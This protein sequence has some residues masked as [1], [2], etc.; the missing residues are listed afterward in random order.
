MRE[1][2]PDT[3]RRAPTLGF[4][5][6][7]LGFVAVL[8]VAGFVVGLLVQRAVLLE[9]LDDEVRASLEEERQKITRLAA[10]R[11]P[12]TGEPFDG[13]V[14]AIFETFLRRNVP[15]EGEVYLTLVAGDPYISTSSP[16]GVRLDRDQTLVE[17]WAARDAGEAATI[18]SAAGPVDY[19]SIPLTSDGDTEGVFVVANFV[20]GERNEIED[21]IRIAAMVSGLLLVVTIGAAWVI[22]GRL[23]QPVRDLTATAQLISDTDLSRRLRVDGRD[24]MADLAVTFNGMLDRLEVAFNTQRSFIDDASHELRTPIQIVRGHLEL[25]GVSPQERTETVELVTDELDRMARIVNDLLLLSKAEQPDFVQPGEEEL[26]DLTVDLFT[27]VNT[28]GERDW[29]LDGC[30][31]GTLLVDRDRLTQAV[32]NLAR[33]AVEHTQAGDQIALGSSRRG[34][35]VR[36]WVR[37]TG[38]GVAAADRH[39][40]FDRF[41]RGQGNRRRSEGAGLGLSIVDAIVTGHRG[42]IELDSEPGHGATFTVVLPCSA[43]ATSEDTLVAVVRE[44]ADGAAI[45]AAG[46]IETR[47]ETRT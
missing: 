19:L 30:D 24:E 35:E 6:R 1:S 20:R 15:G 18:D 21:H 3:R 10:G 45:P 27:K 37:D 8:L 33:N 43:E 38:P 2:R 14:E 13:D 9:R 11:D 40:I 44:D 7:L 28:L 32:L 23:L 12:E 34:S 29:F 22:A 25:M 39:H 4:R 41:A 5:F 42:R 31:V 36:L 46:S 26:S 17:R 47:E 16:T